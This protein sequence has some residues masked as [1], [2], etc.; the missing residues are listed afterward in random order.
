MGWRCSLL[1]L[2][3]M[4]CGC[5]PAARRDEPTPVVPAGVVLRDVT[6]R[7][8][9]LG[10]EETYRVMAPAAFK[11]A[12]PARVVYLLHGNGQGYREWSLYSQAGQWARQGFVLVMPE[13]HS[14]YFMN[15]ATPASDR[16][17]DFVTQDLVADAERGLGPVT[18]E[19]RAIAGVS[20]GGFA[21]LVIGMKHPAEYGFV[22]ALS[23]PVDAAERGFRLQRWGHYWSFRRIFGP[24]G[25]A[26]RQANDPFA[27]VRGVDAA[28]MPFVYLGVGRSEPL[29]GPVERFDRALT[30][31]AVRHE[32][33]EQPG[34]HN[35]GQWGLQL[36][37]L[38]A[39]MQD[40]LR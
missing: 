20:M 3:V 1:V 36:P 27:V 32:F 22:G 29:R 35:W 12:E 6:F 37:G 31:A 13:G 28:R 4:L 7:S 9:A 30:R 15:A 18:R 24:M 17:E 2:A 38:F 19:Q 33:E 8:A 26:S 25:S 5:R 40:H 23:P 11:P 39:A 16:Y 34:G 10:R 21:A 14:S